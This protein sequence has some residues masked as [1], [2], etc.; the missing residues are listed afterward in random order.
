M[1][2]GSRV[3]AP[4]PKQRAVVRGGAFS[5]TARGARD[6][7]DSVAGSTAE[8]IKARLSRDKRNRQEVEAG[9]LFFFP[10]SLCS[11]AVWYTARGARLRPVVREYGQG[12]NRNGAGVQG[13]AE[14]VPIPSA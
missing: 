8:P 12:A 13:S 3:P 10:A 5:E 9:C 7:D 1:P 4:P 14:A 6:Q 11:P 2:G